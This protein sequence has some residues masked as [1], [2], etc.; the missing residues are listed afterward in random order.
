LPLLLPLLNGAE[1]SAAMPFIRD[2][3]EAVCDGGKM[4]AW[5]TIV[6]RG[7]SMFSHEGT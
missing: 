4:S 7:C 3:A 5:V 6:I 2:G 1:E